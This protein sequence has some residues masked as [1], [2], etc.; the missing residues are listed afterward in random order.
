MLVAFSNINGKIL[1]K[2]FLLF[3]LVLKQSFSRLPLTSSTD[4]TALLEAYPWTQYHSASFSKHKW[5]LKHTGMYTFHLHNEACELI[6]RVISPFLVNLE[7]LNLIF[8]QPHLWLK[9]CYQILSWVL[10]VWVL[11]FFMKLRQK[12]ITFFIYW[13]KDHTAGFLVHIQWF[14]VRLLNTIF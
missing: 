3:H 5:N 11:V 7:R 13:R 1:I 9:N 8:N 12:N 2:Y 6:L 4:S 10:I 14:Y